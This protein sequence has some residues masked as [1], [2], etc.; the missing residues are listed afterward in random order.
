MGKEIYW[1]NRNRRLSADNKGRAV[2]LY[3]LG[4]DYDFI[5]S[6]GLEI[7][8][9]RNFSKEYKTD[10]QGILLNESAARLLGFEDISKAVNENIVSAGD[11]VK[12]LGIVANYHHQGLQ[13]AIDPM[14]FRLSPN[15]R[16]AYS[17]KIATGN[18]QPTIA[19][20]EKIW[21]KHFPA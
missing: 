16:D 15:S 21:N 11:T 17:V 18:I 14:I 13:K 6:F 3:N 19:N 10:E 1:T 4:V 20:I 5:P 2:T 8:A 12:I 7:K 9:G